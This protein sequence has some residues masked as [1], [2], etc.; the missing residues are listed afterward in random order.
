[1][2]NVVSGVTFHIHDKNS[3]TLPKS[4]GW[5]SLKTMEDEINHLLSRA[6]S[7]FCT[8]NGGTCTSKTVGLL[9]RRHI[10]ATIAL[11]PTD[12]VD[13]KVM[14]AAHPEFSAGDGSH[15]IRWLLQSRREEE[16]QKSGCFHD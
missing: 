4:A 12:F 14:R 5:L 7:K 8:P 15:S 3:S 10:V 16:Q 11:E 6:E 13:K 9:V 2:F 1:M